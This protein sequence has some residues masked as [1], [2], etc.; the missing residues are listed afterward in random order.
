MQHRTKNPRS[1]FR[2]LLRLIGWIIVGW[3]VV[4]VL[5]VALLKYINPPIWAWK[6]EQEGMNWPNHHWISLDE[7]AP[8][9]QLAVIAGEDQTFSTNHGFDVNSIIA[10]YEHNEHSDDIYGASTI[11]QQTSKNLFLWPTRTYMR[12]AIG[13]WFTLLID[14]LWSKQRVLEVYLNIVQLGPHIYGVQDAAMHLFHEPASKL[15]K[16]QASLLAASLPNPTLYTV[17]PLSPFIVARSAW[18]R[19][20]MKQL[21]YLPL[22]NIGSV[23]MVNWQPVNQ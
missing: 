11:T 18:I 3:I 14:T 15:N 5:L 9:M 17:K 16:Y 21:S 8:P 2:K 6:I 19:Q 7:I 22:E 4:S 13:A 1:W 23:K 20:Q 12:K 10:A